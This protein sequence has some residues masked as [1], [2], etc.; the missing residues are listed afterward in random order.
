MYVR[1]NR[2]TLRTHRLDDFEQCYAMW[3]NPEVTRFIGGKPSTE[4][5]TWSRI[6]SYAGHWALLGFGYWVIQESETQRFVGEIGFADFRRDIA[7]SMQCVPELGFALTPEFHGKGYA[8]EAVRAA[9]VWLEKNLDAPRTVCLIDPEN[10]AS[11]RVAE[12]CGYTVFERATFNGGPALF[13]E[14]YSEP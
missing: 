14:R 5:Q 6:L 8:T 12:K 11:I 10:A 4:Q 7:P 1:T 9:L 13:L 2:L 3:S